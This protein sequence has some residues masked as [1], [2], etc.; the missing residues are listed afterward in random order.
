MEIREIKKENVRNFLH[1]CWV[2]SYVGMSGISKADIDEFF[3]F[4]PRKELPSNFN[5]LGV[6]VDEKLVGYMLYIRKEDKVVLQAIYVDPEYQGKGIGAKLVACLPKNQPVELSVI[7][8]NKKA[9]KFYEKEGFEHVGEKDDFT[10]GG[11]NIK[12]ALY[13]R[14]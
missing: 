5:Q 3:D 12:E 11:R 2:S 10:I 9:R 13:L 1:K 8:E 14:S 4:K 6:F 7:A